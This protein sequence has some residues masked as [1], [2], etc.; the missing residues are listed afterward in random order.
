MPPAVAVGGTT[1]RVRCPTPSGATG[2]AS[3]SRYEVT[4][5]AIGRVEHGDDGTPN[6]VLFGEVAAKKAARSVSTLYA[7]RD[8]DDVRVERAERLDANQLELDG[9][10]GE[11][12]ERMESR[13]RGDAQ[14][15]QRAGLTFSL[16]DDAD[17]VYPI[18]LDFDSAAPGGRAVEAEI[19][20]AQALPLELGL[21]HEL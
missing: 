2:S 5:D 1:R 4:E 11:S 14:V 19:R 10:I 16:A 21:G 13:F 17:P 18:Q 3:T 15:P 9:V 8:D 6:R 12:L 7:D 20:E